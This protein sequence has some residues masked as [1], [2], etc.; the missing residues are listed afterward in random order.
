MKFSE[1][2]AADDLIDYLN[3]AARL[4][5]VSYI[6]KYTKLKSAIRIFTDKR[7]LLRNP[8]DMNDRYEYGK[9]S[10]ENWKHICYSCFS[11]SSVE[12]IAMW[13]MY[14][15]PWSDGIMLSIPP[16]A[17]RTLISDTREL[18]L[19]KQIGKEYVADGKISIEEAKTSLYRVAYTNKH[20][21]TVTG[22]DD[23]NR[24]FAEP[25]CNPE[26]SKLT[27]YVKDIAWDYEKE[28]RLR[29]DLPESCAHSAVF[30]DLDDAFLQQI[31]I[32]TGPRFKGT[33][34]HPLS[35]T[36]KHADI[37]PST[38]SDK[39]HWIPCDDCKC[40]DCKEKGVGSNDKNIIHLPREYMPQSDGGICDARSGEKGGARGGV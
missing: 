12:S 11:A 10:G 15:Q 23:R 14:A 28:V 8:A 4:N 27:G 26:A 6:S 39:I 29:V 24:K 20:N 2:C 36:L 35:D 40:K 1:I 13:S 9:F 33:P 25:Y 18:T 16:K 3:D 5:S 37:S 34:E 17:L 32:I 7:L 30:L 38:F 21:L 22:R 31:K 19:A